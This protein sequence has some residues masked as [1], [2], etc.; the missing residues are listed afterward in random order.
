MAFA[1]P[2]VVALAALLLAAACSWDEEEPRSAATSVPATTVPIQ[3]TEPEAASDGP[4]EACPEDRP[5]LWTACPE[6][7][8]VA[9]IAERAGFAVTGDTQSAL[10]VEGE[11]PSF[12]FWATPLTR[13]P[14]EIAADEGWPALG[15]SAG[16]DL[17]GDGEL[18]QWWVA[19]G[20]VVWLNAGPTA[21]ARLPTPAELA[22]LIRASRELPAPAAR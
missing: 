2:A 14:A 18:W 22:P 17:Y 11:G 5:R 7:T 21:E 13:P 12:Y 1:R 19:Q 3:R 20:H 16:A 15:R 4:G 6:A 9:D 10:I 8:W